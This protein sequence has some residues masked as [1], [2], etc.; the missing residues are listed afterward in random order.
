MTTGPGCTDGGRGH[1][2]QNTGGIQKLERTKER[3]QKGTQPPDNLDCSPVRH[4]SDFYAKKSN[5]IHLC[6]FKPLHLW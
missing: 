2:S 5:V 4:T 1:Q 6:C 3:L